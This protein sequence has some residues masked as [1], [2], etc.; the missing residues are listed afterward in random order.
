MQIGGSPSFLD[1][2]TMTGK[3]ETEGLPSYR[4]EPRLNSAP[5]NVISP[6]PMQQ[7]NRSA[8]F[9]SFFEVCDAG[10]LLDGVGCH[11]LRFDICTFDPA[12][13]PASHNHT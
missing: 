6:K 1:R 5:G 3:V 2:G 12:T 9:R 11:S 8:C 13:P 10:N 7:D 4:G